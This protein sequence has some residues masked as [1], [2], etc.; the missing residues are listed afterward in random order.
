MIHSEV[1]VFPDTGEVV[2]T[3][4]LPIKAIDEKYVELT[5]YLWSRIVAQVGVPPSIFAPVRKKPK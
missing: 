1:T 4:P 5:E 2:S 3:L